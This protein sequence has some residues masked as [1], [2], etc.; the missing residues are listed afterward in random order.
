MFGL[1]G[2]P[3]LHGPRQNLHPFSSSPE[4]P[5]PGEAKL[6][7]S[8]FGLE[9]PSVSQIPL[10]EYLVGVLAA[11]M[12]ALFHPE[13]LKA[14]A[15]V[16]RSYALSRIT[17]AQP[18]CPRDK[19]AHL[20]TDGSC[21]QAWRDP[22][23]FYAS[24]PPGERE[25]LYQKILE[26]VSITAGQV[27]TYQ[28]KIVEAVYHS[29]CGGNTEASHALWQGEP[30]PYLQPVSCSYCSHSPYY[31]Q[32]LI[33]K[34]DK[35]LASFRDNIQPV[36]SSSGLPYVSVLERGPGKRV[37]S[38]QLGSQR[39]SGPQLRQMLDLPSTFFQVR[40]EPE[41]LVFDLRGH[42]HG[43]GLCQYG[44]DGMGKEGYSYQDILS[45]YFPQTKLQHYSAAP[46]Y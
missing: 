28:G 12:P 23:D 2:H 43:V 17:G 20:C 13:A 32:Q 4:P 14:Q 34:K 21:C 38:I 5:L 22:Q 1:T 15:V 40:A 7:L 19:E 39:Y 44:A 26:A 6:S 11:E 35:L 16:A 18:T 33:I 8:V 24:L 31:R 41:G 37:I 27:L 30:L 10:E 25:E 29:T 3:H 42:G 36:A 45:H 46:L 9:G